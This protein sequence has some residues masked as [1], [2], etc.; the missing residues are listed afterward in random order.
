[1]NNHTINNARDDAPELFTGL[2]QATKIDDAS[3]NDDVQIVVSLGHTAGPAK[4]KT[5]SGPEKVHDVLSV[6][7]IITEIPKLDTVKNKNTTTVSKF[8]TLTREKGTL[9]YTFTNIRDVTIMTGPQL[10]QHGIETESSQTISDTCLQAYFGSDSPGTIEY[11][12]C[13]I[14]VHKKVVVDGSEQEISLVITFSV[15]QLHNPNGYVLEHDLSASITMNL[16][17]DT[18]TR[19][20]TMLAEVAQTRTDTRLVLMADI[21]AVARSKVM[22][23]YKKSLQEMAIGSVGQTIKKFAVATASFIEGLG[24]HIKTAVLVKN[25]QGKWDIIIEPIAVALSAFSDPTKTASASSNAILLI[26]TELLDEVSQRLANGTLTGLHLNG[27][28]MRLKELSQDDAL[29][30]KIRQTFGT[31]IYIKNMSLAT[32]HAM[33]ATVDEVSYNCHEL[34]ETEFVS[35]TFLSRVFCNTLRN[36]SLVLISNVVPLEQCNTLIRILRRLQGSGGVDSKTANTAVRD[37]V[38]NANKDMSRTLVSMEHGHAASTMS[39]LRHLL[40]SPSIAFHAAIEQSM[41]AQTQVVAVETFRSITASSRHMVSLSGHTKTSYI[42]TIIR[43]LLGHPLVDD[44]SVVYTDISDIMDRGVARRN[45][46]IISN[47]TELGKMTKSANVM[48]T[49]LM[50]SQRLVFPSL[51]ASTGD[52]YKELSPEFQD[53]ALEALANTGSL[54]ASLINS[55]GCIHVTHPDLFET[56]FDTQECLVKADVLLQQTYYGAVIKTALTVDHIKTT[57]KS[58][59]TANDTQA[60]T[61]F[62]AFLNLSPP[63]FFLITSASKDKDVKSTVRGIQLMTPEQRTVTTAEIAEF[64]KTDMLY[65]MSRTSNAVS[66]L[67]ASNHEAFLNI[68]AVLLNVAAHRTITPPAQTAPGTVISFARLIH[69]LILLKTA[70]LNRFGF[71]GD[72][73]TAKQKSL[74][75]PT[76]EQSKSE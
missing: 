45:A 68:K 27:F 28:Y 3:L 23:V 17:K 65:F 12:K 32:T 57:I 7:N 13:S 24:Q 11:L 49:T 31:S 4:G 22:A 52:L 76:T 14:V 6:D 16:G 2:H 43:S 10:R 8:G 19:S 48:M 37:F 51:I 66:M 30:G 60:K 70:T 69:S 36:S 42:L 41:K 20:L 47:I 39:A 53:K 35:V 58:I 73:F 5:V 33:V 64:S 44:T 46:A 63:E 61:Q 50:R 40:S 18:I 67:M 21:A 62:L 72:N 34:S 9:N 1:M 75:A 25:D 56:S 26:F 29:L 15:L 74:P 54:P 59:L 38:D 71:G 55:A